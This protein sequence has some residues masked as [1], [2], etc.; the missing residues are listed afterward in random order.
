MKQVYKVLLSIGLFSSNALA[1]KQAKPSTIGS[2]KPL[3]SPINAPKRKT[4]GL[5]A[6]FAEAQKLYQQAKYAEA[7]LE[8]DRLYRKYPEHDGTI[9][10]Y[11]RTLYKLDRI[12]ELQLARAIGC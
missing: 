8:L 12:Q 10:Y 4:T 3:A 7:L 5:V 1:E 9:L 2:S 6:Q 11:G